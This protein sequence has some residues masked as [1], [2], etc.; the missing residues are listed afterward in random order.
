MEFLVGAVVYVA[1]QVGA[2]AALVSATGRLP[3]AP[4]LLAVSALSAFAAVAV[5][6]AV[7]VRAPSAIGIRRVPPRTVVLAIGLGIGVWLLSR[8]LII[9]YV[10]VT[11]DSSD[12]RQS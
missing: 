12:P 8:L 7:R 10:S 6:L 5:A 4:V 11:G 2:G 1:V 9:L 3:S